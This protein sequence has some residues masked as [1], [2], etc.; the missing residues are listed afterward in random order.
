MRAKIIG[1]FSD[2]ALKFTLLFKLWEIQTSLRHDENEKQLLQHAYHLVSSIFL[3]KN[4][5]IFLSL[6]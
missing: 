2:T 4:S 1:L 6:F 3:H 5:M